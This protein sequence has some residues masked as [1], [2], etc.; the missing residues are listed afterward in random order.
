MNHTDD[1]ISRLMQ[2]LRETEPPAGMNG[3]ILARIEQQTA[4]NSRSPRARWGSI[5]AP[6]RWGSLLAW[7]AGF[8]LSALLAI[9]ILVPGSRRAEHAPANPTLAQRTRTSVAP[10]LQSPPPNFATVAD[11]PRTKARRAKTSVTGHRSH[12]PAELD[13][14]NHPAPQMPLTDQEKLLLRIAHRAPPE[15]LAMATAE[16][17][18]ARRA[19]EEAEFQKFFGPTTAAVNP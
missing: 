16:V 10:R 11:I 19:E 14:F 2:S 12:V 7:T 15:Q 13:A 9:A 4:A 3:R 1:A 6:H 18:T 5:S 17:R 8:T